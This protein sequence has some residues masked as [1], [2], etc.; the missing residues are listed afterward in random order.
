MH[1]ENIRVKRGESPL[2]VELFTSVYNSIRRSI[3]RVFVQEECEYV[4][5][6]PV[7]GAARLGAPAQ[8]A[9]H[10]RGDAP[11]A[12]FVSPRDQPDVS[13]VWECR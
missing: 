11:K 13:G 6:L 2:S 8:G 7:E 12:A 4:R 3:T 9:A 1:A 10:R 5:R